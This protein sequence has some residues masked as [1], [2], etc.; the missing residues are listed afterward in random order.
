ME[1]CIN[2]LWDN[3]EGGFMDS[4]DHVLGVKVKGIQDSPHPAANSLSILLL[5]KLFVMTGKRKYYQYAEK[6]LKIFS[7][8]VKD[9]GVH[10]GFYYS[11]LDAYFNGMKLELHSNPDSELSLSARSVFVPYMNM[12][13]GEDEGYALACFRETCHEPLKNGEALQDFTRDKKYLENI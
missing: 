12:L 8:I 5:L 7:P 2:I 9:M 10:A 6:A 4:D 3:E 1:E 11:A 13:Y